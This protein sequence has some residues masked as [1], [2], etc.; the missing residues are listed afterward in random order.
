MEFSSRIQELLDGMSDEDRY[1]YH[2]VARHCESADY[3]KIAIIKFIHFVK[4]RNPNSKLTFALEMD[5][6]DN[7][8]Q[9]SIFVKTNFGWVGCYGTGKPFIVANY[10]EELQHLMNFAETAISE[11]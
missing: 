5:T 11:N 4:T 3:E 7:T 8:N 6:G 10:L 9:A 2:S 1:V